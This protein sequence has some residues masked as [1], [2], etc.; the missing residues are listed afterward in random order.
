[1]NSVWLLI[2][3]LLKLLAWALALILT[4]LVFLLVIT[5]ISIAYSISAMMGHGALAIFLVL[6]YLAFYRPL[7]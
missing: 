7:N 3:M 5:T 2:N 1:M 6:T 4:A